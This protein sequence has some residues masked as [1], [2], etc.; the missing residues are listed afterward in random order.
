MKTEHFYF[1]FCINLQLNNILLY[2]I[3]IF[4]I[5]FFIA[6]IT[7]GCDG[8]TEKHGSFHIILYIY[9]IDRLAQ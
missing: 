4:W 2:L 5:D 8:R 1:M 7:E 9:N 3:H 6:L